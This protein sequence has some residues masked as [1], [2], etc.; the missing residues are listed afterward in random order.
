MKIATRLKLATLFPSLMAVLITGSLLFSYR[1]VWTAQEKDKAAQQVITGMNDLSGYVSEYV[2]FHE[3]R[4]LE[5]FL[6]EHDQ[7]L[8]IVSSIQTNNP[9]QQHVLEQIGRDLDAMRSSFLK[10][11]SNHERYASGGFFELIQELENRLAGRLLVWSRGVVSEAA[12]LE[13]LIDQELTRTEKRI[14]IL[15]FSLILATALFLTVG[16]VTMTRTVTSSLRRLRDGTERIG[17]GDFDHRIALPARDEI[18]ELAQSFNRMTEHLQEVT[19]SRDTLEQEIQERKQA[20]ASLREQREWLRVTLNSIGDAVVATDAEGR[21]SFLNAVASALTGWSP[22]DAGG[23]RIQDVLKTEDEFSGKP[24]EDVVERVL[25]EGCVVNMA[26]HTVLVRRDGSKIPIEDSAAPIQGEAG[27]LM[28]VVIVFHDV[29]EKRRAEQ[30]LRDSSEKLRIVAD[31][32]YDWEHW[33]SPEDRFV[34]VSPSCERISG[35]PSEAFIKDPGLYLRI[36]HPEDR[37]RVAAHMREDQQDMGSCELEFRIVHRDGR[38]RWIGHVC[39]AVLDEKGRFL[40]RRSSNRDITDQKHAEEALLQSREELEARVLDRTAKLEE[41]ARQLARLSS[42]L[43]VA[44]QRERR[45]LA[46]ILHDHLQQ[47]LVGAKMGLEIFSK[48][49]DGDQQKD[50]AQVHELLVEALQTS[51]SLSAQLAPNVLFEGS[52]ASALGWLAESMSS[53]HP[54]RV[55]TEIDP[56]ITVEREEARVLLFESVRELLFNVVKHAKTSSAWLIMKR[57]E[58]KQLRITVRD[59]GVGFDPTLLSGKSGGEQQFGLFSIRERLELLDG[60]MEIESTP[61]LG[62]AFTLYVPMESAIGA[63]P[64]DAIQEGCE[65]MESVT[66]AAPAPDASGAIR[67]MLV[68][69]HT[70][71]RQ[72]LS[73]MLCSQTDMEVVAEA[74][75]GEE[76]V[77]LARE[78]RPD[79]IL[80]DINMP[81]MNGLEATKQIL[82]ES[83]QSRIIGLSVYDD[84]ETTREMLRIGAVACMMKSSH[85]NDYL[86]AIRIHT[87]P[88]PSS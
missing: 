28:G 35:Y 88:A 11:V 73:S 39:Q 72:G 81:K 36:I 1:A 46:G 83:P 78:I 38:E 67:I 12:Y 54:I 75:D 15:I 56:G 2:L 52:L 5:Q 60:G 20:E 6:I 68:D 17:A 44:E 51:R 7:V 31:F 14:N 86:K 24:A 42:Q 48:P 69:D 47:Y 65:T 26:N 40:G 77:R 76:A 53:I 64:G 57:D 74:T 58:L 32:T 50:L 87:R 80:M 19:V 85:L 45:R 82:L 13:R 59:R 22:E 61:G 62:A 8:E 71:M 29:T 34:Y 79:L 43:T 49:L 25:T 16:A 33:R 66:R 63:D 27:R 23:N 18:G 70:A 21:V 84:T 9:M 10:L 37:N 41:R 55:E 3:G 4:P 30:R